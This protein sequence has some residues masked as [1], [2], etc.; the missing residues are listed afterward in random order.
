MIDDLE[1]NDRLVREMIEAKGLGQS[2]LIRFPA[3]LASV[4]ATGAW[5]R[6]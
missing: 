4:M 2:G 3:T 6:V 5:R 1:D